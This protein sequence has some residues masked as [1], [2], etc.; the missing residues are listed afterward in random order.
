MEKVVINAAQRTVKGKQVSQ[1]RRQG[2]LPGVL[3]G[4]HLDATPI[5]MDLKE[6]TRLL[7]GLTSSS[8]VTINLDGKEHAALVREKQRD[9]IRGSLLHVDFQAVTLTEKLRTRVAIELKGTAPAIK[10]FDGILVTGVDEIEVEAFPQDLPERIVVDLSNLK[11]IGD[12]IYV[13]DLVHLD[14]VEILAHPDEMIAI[15]TAQAREEAAEAIAEEAGAAEPEVIERGKK[16]E[17]GEE[18]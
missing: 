2:K 6:T 11:Q 12:G 15:I 14:K 16:E 18:A 7:S 9:Y 13:R 8:L 4:R 17:E 5:V 1:L 3:Y 10:E